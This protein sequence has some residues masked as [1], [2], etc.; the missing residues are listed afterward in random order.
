MSD[1][2]NPLVDSDSQIN[3]NDYYESPDKAFAHAHS[4]A[5]YVGGAGSY[6]FTEGV[7]KDHD[8]Y[9]SP[10][11][12]Q[13]IDGTGWLTGIP[14]SD[15]TFAWAKALEDAKT[16]VW[17]RIQQGQ[18]PDAGAV[19]ELIATTAGVAGDLLGAADPIGTGLTYE[20]SW[21]LNHFRPFRIAVDG[22]TGVPEVIAGYA[23]TWSNIEGC[24]ESVSQEFQQ[25]FKSGPGQWTGAAH[26]AYLN[27]AVTVAAALDAAS[28]SAKAMSIL[29]KTI[30]DVVAGIR[31]LV[32]ALISTLVGILPDIVEALVGDEEQAGAGAG[33]KVAKVVSEVAKLVEATKNVISTIS[34]IAGPLAT[35]ANTINTAVKDFGGGK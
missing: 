5:D 29:I 33:A 19:I 2:G 1:T 28:V 34:A 35:V 6:L 15:D 27:M 16:E 21:L 22:L 10:V 11:T 9:A 14:L 13:P 12:G 17:G 8:N 4:P 24:L 23:K 31:S 32:I 20:V 3:P 25:T 7:G 26:D 30:G 18:W